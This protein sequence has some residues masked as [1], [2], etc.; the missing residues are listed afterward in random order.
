MKKT[1][2]AA[3]K[4][5][6]EKPTIFFDQDCGL[7]QWSVRFLK[8]K[9][10]KNLIDFLPLN[11]QKGMEILK[12]AKLKSGKNTMQ[13]GSV[14][15]SKSNEIFLESNA[16]IHASLFLNFPWKLLFLTKIIPRPI[17]DFFYQLVAKNR[18]QLSCFLH[19][20]KQQKQR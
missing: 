5:E 2:T 13:S 12:K 10:K 19:L 16:I 9:S 6:G 17:R 14:I 3:A 20:E 15:F 7:C 8:N 11:S 18:K 1:R 4:I